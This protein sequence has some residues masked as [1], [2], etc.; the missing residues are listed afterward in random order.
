MSL[1]DSSKQEWC[2][3]NNL[4]QINAGS[5]QRMADAIEKVA[6][7]HREALDSARRFEEYWRRAQEEVARLRRSAAALRGQI[8]KLKKAAEAAGGK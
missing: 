5:F 1:R 8:T 7:P 2:G 6:A 3:G 4:D